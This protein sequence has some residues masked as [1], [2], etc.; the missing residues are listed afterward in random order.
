M[1]RRTSNRFDPEWNIIGL[2]ALQWGTL[3]GFFVLFALMVSMETQGPTV[4]PNEEERLAM[5]VDESPYS[6]ESLH[7]RM[8][9]KAIEKVQ[10]YLVFFSQVQRRRIIDGLA[11][12]T[13]YLELYKEIFQKKKIPLELAY[14]PLIESGFVERAVSPAQAAGVWQFIEE[15]GRRYNLERTDWKDQR[16]DPIQSARAAASLLRN[17]HQKF[18]NWE[19]ALA[20]YNAGANTVKWARRANRRKGKEENFWELKLPDETTEYVPAFIAAV[21]IAKNP[22]AFGFDEIK[23]QPRM[24]FDHIK[25]SSGTQLFEVAA[26]LDVPVE[27]V[28]DLNPNLIKGEVPP[29]EKPHLLRVPPGTPRAVHNKLTGASKRLKDWMLY[30]VNDN[31]TVDYLANR[32]SSKPD[33]ILKIN[34]LETDEEL[35]L[36]EFLIIPL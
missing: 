29:G 33:A 12:S 7:G 28:W 9:P 17:L 1:A 18:N 8:P 21:I 13:R 2:R 15:T 30:R 11:R 35:L 23:F 14:L 32:F 6:L 27:V 19:L 3:A 22:Q 20:S 5:L 34:G 16:L 10:R 25:V 31:D 4:L 36:R 26:Q 24:A